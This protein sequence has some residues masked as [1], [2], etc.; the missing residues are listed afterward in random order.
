MENINNSN[1]TP[2][3]GKTSWPES[4][5]DVGEE[6]IVSV[7]CGNSHMHWA[8]HNGIEKDFKPVLFWRTPHLKASD[9]EEN[10]ASV[11]S[12]HLP[13]LAHSF[14]FGGEAPNSQKAKEIAA[15]RPKLSVYVVS[16][17]REQADL[18]FVIW[19]SV[20]SR[21]FVMQGD[22]FFSTEEGRY[23][24]MGV[25]RLAVLRGAGEMY[26]YPALVFDGGTATTYTAAD[27]KGHILG[28]GISPGLG[29]KLL[30]LKEHTAALPY[31]S[32]EAVLE[33]V[34]DAVS[35]K[36][37][38]IFA[39][40]THDAILVDIL[41]EFA[42]KMRMVISKW[43]NDTNKIDDMDTRLLQNTKKVVCV[44]G[45]DAYILAQLL[46]NNI[47]GVIDSE[48][49]SGSF[50]DVKGCEIKHHKHI[51]HYGIASALRK[52][53]NNKQQLP[54]LDLVQDYTS[55]LGMR[56]AKAFESADVDGDHIFRGSIQSYNLRPNGKDLFFIKYDDADKEHVDVSEL[57]EMLVLYKE[58]GEKKSDNLT[59]KKKV[60]KRKYNKIKNDKKESI[61]VEMSLTVSD[62]KAIRSPKEQP[63]VKRSQPGAK[64]SPPA[65]KRSQ[66]VAKRPPE[67]DGSSVQ[68]KEDRNQEQRA[69][70][71]RKR[72]RP[73]NSSGKPLTYITSRVAKTF[74]REVYFG[75]IVDY[76]VTSKLWKIIYDDGDQEEF[77][78]KDLARSLKLY[79]KTKQK[80]ALSNHRGATEK[81]SINN[82]IGKTQA[83]VL[84]KSDVGQDASETIKKD[85]SKKQKI[86]AAIVVSNTTTSSKDQKKKKTEV[87]KNDKQGIKKA[88]NNA[89][90]KKKMKK[91]TNPESPTQDK[92]QSGDIRKNGDQ[93]NSSTSVTKDDVLS[94]KTTANHIEA[95]VSNDIPQSPKL[96]GDCK[97]SSAK[98]VKVASAEKQNILPETASVK[99]FEDRLEKDD[100]MESLLV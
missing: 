26:G 87:L 73:S 95:K 92:A 82:Q 100:E 17:V 86:D 47:G 12:R 31:L 83:R 33:R 7:V 16:Q 53:T 62:K 94:G 15:N 85:T 37:F 88:G 2:L 36:P 42:L 57:R 48:G 98:K 49:T 61:Q 80:D 55:F 70:N 60:N 10:L 6:Y 84:N 91:K 24:T 67:K 66:P 63:P 99:T 39:Q 68:D 65:A 89:A 21:I 30:S 79:Q 20:P 11:L 74:E 9:L 32:P 69:A 38:N 51:I 29:S 40:D 50:S 76:N 56:V 13:V 28:G 71:T 97:H 46:S 1:N 45:G 14:V 75:S 27:S 96:D 5:P 93:I 4:I 41:S 3:I 90:D 77:D 81:V 18:L 72:G 59:P 44:C 23:H 22:D 35:V 52:Q 64:R 78:E 8:F 25:D 54:S 43:L 58:H 19:S 34:R